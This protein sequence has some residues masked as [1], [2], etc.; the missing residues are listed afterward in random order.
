MISSENKRE[1]EFRKLS[2]HL[3]DLIFQFTRRPD[4]SYYVPIASKGIENIFGCQP[5]DVKDSFDAI[6]RVLHPDDAER[7]LEDIEHSAK[8]ISEFYC[9]FRVC[10]PGKPVQ[11]ILSRSSPEALPDGSVTWYGFNANITEQRNTLEQ[12]TTLYKKQEAILKAIPDLIFVIGNDKIIYEY[13]SNVNDLLAAPPEVFMGKKY[14]DIISK[15]ASAVMDAALAETDEKG[16]SVGQQYELSLPIGKF[17]FELSVVPIEDETTLT[18]KYLV[19]STNITERKIKDD[20]IQQLSIAVEQSSTSIVI[21]DLNGNIE[22]VNQFFIDI[23]GYSREEAIGSNINILQ[24]GHTTSE[25]YANMWDTI[26]KG[27]TWKG[28]FLNRKKNGELFWE[29]ATI[30]PVR[31]KNGVIEHFL[32]I[33][34]DITAQKAT[35]EKLRKIAW[36]QSH[37][38]RGPLTDIMGIINLMK[39]EISSEEKNMLLNQL[40][41]AAKVLDKAIHDIVDET[42]E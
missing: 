14:S 35:T 18:K 36:N 31:N 10:I 8:N 19:V 7:V 22:Y 15:E 4:G 38:V 34:T 21:T 42:K 9:E 37:Q 40:E 23:T 2:Y 20:K 28:E 33:K 3:P 12:L 30:T 17:W 1:D 27:Y 5:E 16:I 39:M 11:W 6:A 25:Q 41:I 32:G 29:E 24:T 13:H 26:I